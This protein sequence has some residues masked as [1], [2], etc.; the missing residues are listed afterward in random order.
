MVG[1]TVIPKFMHVVLELFTEPVNQSDSTLLFQVIMGLCI[2]GTGGLGTTSNV[3]RQQ[4]S[5][6]HLIARLVFLQ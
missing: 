5:L 1:S 4:C 3:P 2:S 6:G